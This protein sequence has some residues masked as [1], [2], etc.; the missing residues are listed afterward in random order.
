MDA[1]VEVERK[2]S[3]TTRLAV[4]IAVSVCCAFGAGILPASADEHG[5]GYHHG[6][7][8]RGGGW[9]GG[10]RGGGYRG[11]GDYD[12][13]Y[14][15]PPPV[16]YGDPYGYPPPVVYGPGIVVQVPGISIGVR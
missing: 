11:G 16:V 4:V 1:I 3:R 6:G 9:G 7:G 8:G 5:H 15:Y 2:A 10:H 13:G 12:D 14:D